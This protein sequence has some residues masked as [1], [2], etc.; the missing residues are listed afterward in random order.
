MQFFLFLKNDEDKVLF[1]FKFDLLFSF[2]VV[3]VDVFEI[4]L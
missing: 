1:I 4:C 2:I 3:G